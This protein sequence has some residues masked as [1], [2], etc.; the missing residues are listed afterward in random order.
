MKVAFASPAPLAIHR[1][2]R[3]PGRSP[4]REG[5]YRDQSDSSPPDCQLSVGKSFGKGNAACWV[6]ASLEDAYPQKEHLL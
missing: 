5:P 4:G 3:G 1:G 6:W 2:D